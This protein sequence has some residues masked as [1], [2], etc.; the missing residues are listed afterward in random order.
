MRAEELRV[1][2]GQFN[3]LG[4]SVARR[5]S[6]SATNRRYH[7]PFPAPLEDRHQISGYTVDA[8]QE[9][10][11]TNQSSHY[12]DHPKPN[13]PAQSRKQQPPQQQQEEADDQDVRGRDVLFLVI[14]AIN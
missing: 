1:V 13:L 6:D 10:R 2:V 12:A 11:Q 3:G 14:P 8:E 5:E 4:R 7:F 9:R